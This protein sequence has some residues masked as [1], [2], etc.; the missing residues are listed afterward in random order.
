MTI[1]RF[2]V[3][4]NA[5]RFPLVST[6]GQRAVFV[7]ALDAAPRTNSNFTGSGES[8]DY[9][10]AQILY[11]ENIMPVAEGIKSVGYREL[12]TATEAANDFD[13]IFA[14][15]DE[16]ENT[17]LYSPAAGKNYIYDN[18]TEQWTTTTFLEIH[19]IELDPTSPNTEATAKV[20]YAYVDG[21]TFICYSRLLGETAQPASIT[22]NFNSA[23]TVT[24]EVIFNGVTYTLGVDTELTSVVDTWTLDISGLTLAYGSY[25]VESRATSAV[26]V[27]TVTETTFDYF[28]TDCSLVYWDAVTKTLEPATSLVTNIPFALGTIDGIAASNGYLLLYSDISVAWAPFDGTAFNYD[29]YLNGAFTGSGYQIPEDVQGNIKAC[30][31]LPGGFVLFTTKNAVASTYHSQNVAAPWIF[32]EIAGCGGI[33][34]YEQATVEG[35]LSSI[36]AYT[37]TGLQKISLN[38]SEEAYPDVSDFIAGRYF[39]R[40]NF[41]DQ[42]LRQTP[43]TL[44][45]YV[46]LTNIANRYLVVSYGTF[47][48]I[49]SFALVYDMTLKRWGKLRMVHRD[50]FYYSYGVE[51][52]SLTYGMLGDVAYDNP[53]LTTYD[54]ASGQSNAIVAAQHGLAF[55]R[56]DGSVTLAGWSNQERD[57]DT[58]VAIIGRVQLT[59]TSHTQFNRLEVEGLTSGRLYIQPSYNGRDLETAEELVTIESSGDLRVA[60]SMI[61]CK[62]F[63]IVVEGSFDLSTLIVEATTSGRV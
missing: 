34:S 20:T 57:E 61:D 3:A 15:R 53:D 6:K 27:I 2:K 14:L 38:S 22:G 32:K 52:A 1:Q 24:L 13:Q 46:K 49:Y 26:P 19:G 4:L 62:N 33:E 45:L 40:Y 47:T 43:V 9:N 54:A 30:I 10:T 5:A 39:E 63:N 41:D 60:G 48:K 12:I 28:A 58:A 8:T 51:T 55:L 50:C 18:I 36:I 7:P 56:Q 21:R 23:T 16:D 42:T 37:T 31:G 59:R 11:G 44:D 25:P 29:I 35:S 17:V